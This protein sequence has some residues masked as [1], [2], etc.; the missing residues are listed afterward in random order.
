MRQIKNIFAI[1]LVLSLSLSLICALD[2]ENVQRLSFNHLLY[3]S[4][5]STSPL[6]ISP[7][8]EAN[9][10][11]K[12][13][14]SGGQFIRDVRI[15]LGLPAEFAPYRD[16]DRRKI[17]QMNPDDSQTI[18]FNIISLPATEDGVYK[19][20]I[21]ARYVNYVGDERE[22]NNTIS[23][24]V[25]SSPTLLVELISSEIY[26]GSSMGNVKIKV[27]NDNSGNVK[28]LK[29]Q[30]ANSTEYSVIGSDLDYVGDLNS[31]DYS[32]VSFKISM[33]DNFKTLEL[34]IILSYKDALNKDYKQLETLIFK[35]PTAAEAGIKKSY[36][37]LYLVIIIVAVGGYIYYRRYNK[38]I[39][40]AKKASLSIASKF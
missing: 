29:V 5:I 35:V 25:G 7:G 18:S 20:N 37:W 30:L 21:I 6:E 31:D 22:E 36:A 14:N 2:T 9:L 15:D 12:I 24:I 38:K 33:T 27:I 17:V 26:K 1:L 19:I 13:E 32:D 39:A 16:T 40:K 3:I 34:P 8:Q 10:S 4:N 11:F 23:L 28:F